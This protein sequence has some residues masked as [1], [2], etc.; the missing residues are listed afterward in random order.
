VDRREL[1]NATKNQIHSIRASEA[2]AVQIPARTIKIAVARDFASDSNY[3]L[4]G[5]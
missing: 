4:A 2:S 1:L 3:G 5:I